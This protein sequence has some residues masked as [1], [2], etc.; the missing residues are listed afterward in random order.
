MKNVMWCARG[1]SGE[2]MMNTV[3]R[4]RSEVYSK[5]FEVQD[6]YFQK[7]YWKQWQRSLKA[8]KKLGYQV[9]KVVLVPL[10]DWMKVA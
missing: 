1:P 9:I 8:Y 10:T 3:S 4:T 7:E 2:L 5:L 6:E